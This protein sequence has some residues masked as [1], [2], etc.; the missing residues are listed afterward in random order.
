M[1][2]VAAEIPSM[3]MSI[4]KVLAFL[5]YLILVVFFLFSQMISDGSEASIILIFSP[6]KV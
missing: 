2:I 1:N 3:P 5:F 6:S 4:K